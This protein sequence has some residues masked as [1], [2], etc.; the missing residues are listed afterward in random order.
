M[1]K[2]FILV[3]LFVATFASAQCYT[4]FKGIEIKGNIDAFGAQLEKQGFKV[5]EKAPIIYMYSGKFSGDEVALWVHCTVKTHTVYAVQVIFDDKDTREL[6]QN[7][8]NSLKDLLAQKY[9]E[10]AEK[11]VPYGNDGEYEYSGDICTRW[12][13]NCGGV[14]LKNTH[15]VISKYHSMKVVMIMYWS[16]EGYELNK[17]ELSE[18]L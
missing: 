6:I 14:T 8:Y 17:L 5:E 13:D 18:D 4:K 7:R 10:P 2:L 3:F 16:E 1:K 12:K 15:L 11:D 9:G